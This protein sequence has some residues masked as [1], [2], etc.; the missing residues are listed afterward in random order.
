MTTV[1]TTTANFKYGRAIGSQDSRNSFTHSEKY[2]LNAV[3]VCMKIIMTPNKTFP[4]VVFFYK[5]QCWKCMA[6][7]ILV[8]YLTE[9]NPALD[10]NGHPES[11]T[12]C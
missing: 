11:C 4:D 1:K 6:K 8:I 12:K 5:T 9:T 3:N 7:A 10:S 2:I